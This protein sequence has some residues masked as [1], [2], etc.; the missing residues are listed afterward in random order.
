MERVRGIAHITHY[1]YG[2]VDHARLDGGAPTHRE[3]IWFGT[4]NGATLE[5]VSRGIA[6]SIVSGGIE[7]DAGVKMRAVSMH[8]MFDDLWDSVNLGDT[9]LATHIA[10]PGDPH[11]AAGYLKL[12]EAEVLYVNVD[13]DTMTDLL[14][15]SGDP[16]DA[17]GAATK[18]YVDD[19]RYTDAEAIAA[20][21]NGTYLKLSGGVMH[22]Q[23]DMNSHNIINLDGMY[24]PGDKSQNIQPGSGQ[25]LYLRDGGG[26][27]RISMQQGN[28][29]V[30]RDNSGVS[31]VLV[32]DS[33][34][35][36][37]DEN[38]TERMSVA[39]NEIILN[40]QQVKMPLLTTSG[41]QPNVYYDASTGR[42]YR[43]TA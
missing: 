23:L 27:I 18:A 19:N 12:S 16:V 29:L 20:V 40:V 15:L 39:N 25:F 14:L 42:L 38:G 33:E 3:Y 6:G 35:A 13:G 17:L 41:N 11:A 37:Q 43:S 22:G 21:D 36:F 5:N 31:R 30:L 10:D 32:K 7:H 34:T 1:G 2:G 24:G 26:G 4:L 8:Q 28:S 9:D